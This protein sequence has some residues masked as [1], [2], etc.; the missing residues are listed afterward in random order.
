MNERIRIGVLGCGLFSKHFVQL[1]KAF[2]CVYGAEPFILI[3]VIAV[4]DGF[5]QKA[6][7]TVRNGLILFLLFLQLALQL[8]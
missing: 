5:P 7:D 1:F 2:L 4:D 3:S 6:L 8:T